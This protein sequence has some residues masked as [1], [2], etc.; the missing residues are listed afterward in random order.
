MGLNAEQYEASSP[1][2]PVQPL[3]SCNHKYN[4]CCCCLCCS[5]AAWVSAGAQQQI[6]WYIKRPC[7]QKKSSQMIFEPMMIQAFNWCPAELWEQCTCELEVKRWLKR[8]PLGLK[9]RS[10][11]F[12]VSF[13]YGSLHLLR[14]SVGTVKRSYLTVMYET[15]DF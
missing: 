5:K 7:S 8:S 9:R 10:L 15:S 3:L 4:R 11:C 6:D 2:P 14:H 13:T 1:P 12:V